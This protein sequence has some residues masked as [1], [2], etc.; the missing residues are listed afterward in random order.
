[1]TRKLLCYFFVMVTC[2]G[3]T[4][5]IP[6]NITSSTQVVVN[7]LLIPD[8]TQELTLVYSKSLDDGGIYYDAVESAQA[9]LY[10]DATL[11]GRFTKNG[12][13]SWTI[14]HFPQEGS[15]YQ[16]KIA[17]PNYDTLYANTTMPFASDIKK[18]TSRRYIKNFTQ[19]T[20]PLNQWVFCINA[21]FDSTWIIPDLV[22]EIKPTNKLIENLATDHRNA[23]AFNQDGNLNDIIGTEA[24]LPAYEFYIRLLATPEESN[25]SIESSF[26]PYCYVVFRTSSDEYDQY[27]KTSLQKMLQYSDV[28]DPIQ[29]F[30]ENIVY[31]N[32]TNG[33]GI[34]GAYSDQIF[35]Y[36]NIEN[37]IE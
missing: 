26:S 35:C 12:S 34:F 6:L 23:D 14:E 8:S 3:C 17:V 31:S 15:V 2:W 16:L 24:T 28:D 30:D 22:P 13:R 37:V 33:I 10:K 29:W 1:M 19:Q 11:I 27:M 5:E 25:F 18:T 9:E 4:N 21:D 32:I 7:C 36:G 20:Q